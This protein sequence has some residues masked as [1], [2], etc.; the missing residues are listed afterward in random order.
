M[1]HKQ[2]MLAAITGAPIDR[3]PWAPRF[4]LWYKA[5]KLAGTLPSRFRNASLAEIVDALDAGFH[6]VVPDFRDLRGP[7]DDVDRGL[8]LYNLHMLPYKT[9]LDGVTR[10]VRIDCDRTRVVW[11]T[12][13]GS[14]SATFAY[15]DAMR[16]AGITIT[17][18]EEQAFKDMRDYAA[19]QFIFD[20]ARV[21]P[22]Y[23]G[24]AE[25]ARSIGDRGLAVGWVNGAG[26]PMHLIQRELMPL[27]VF[28]FEM[29]D[30]PKELAALVDVIGGYWRR[31]LAVAA[32]SPA[33]VLFLGGNYDAMITYPPFFAEHIGPWLR[34]FADDLHSRG[35]YLLTHTDGEND[36]LLQHYICAHIDVADSVCPSPMTRL[37][38][39]QVRDTFAGRIT[40]MG[41][42]PS[43]ALLPSSMPDREFDAFI[44]SFFT[45]LGRGDHLI[46]GI[47]DTTPPGA[48][49][50]R[51][52]K[53]GELARRFRVG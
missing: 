32:A 40:V 3:L 33:E 52:E 23:D 4:D 31:M 43:V 17:H 2:R 18:L 51:I 1:T 21:E 7:D 37:T 12:P 44:D 5:N 41:G 38:L 50:S 34:S 27:D 25:F 22:N 20:N 29:H 9:T 14:V 24:Y 47:S 46:L 28:F 8:G 16:R 45:D 11:H 13:K 15:T 35:K 39:K 26:S 6:A 42:V 49:F 36:G 48:D 19:L 10:D 53:I 30:H